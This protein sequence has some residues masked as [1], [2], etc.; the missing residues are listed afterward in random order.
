MRYKGILLDIDNTLYEYDSAHKIAKNS[1][2]EYCKNKFKLTNTFIEEA[3]DIA[4]KKVHI[5]LSETASSHNRL[6]YIQKMLE[7]LNINPLEYSLDIYNIYWDTFL[8]NMNVFNGVY[9]LLE[10]YKGKICLVTDLTSHIQHRKVQKLQLDKYCT[11]IVTSEEAGREKPHPYMFMSA[12][13]KLDLKV[14]DVCMVGDSFKKD[15]AGASNLNIKSIWLNSEEKKE[16]Y[17]DTLVQEV[18]TF[19]EILELV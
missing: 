12:L 13:A 4:R 3:Y 6:L 1:V 19:K 7:H 2:V 14:E 8:E 9:E 16:N 10:M 18:K 11:K 5:E 15:I 17:D